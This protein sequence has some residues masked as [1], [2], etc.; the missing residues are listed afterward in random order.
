MIRRRRPVREIPFSFDSFLDVVANVVGIIIRLI[1]V[2]WVGARSY[3]SLTQLHAQRGAKRLASAPASLPADPLQDEVARRQRELAAAQ[4]R[5]VDQLRQFRLVQTEEQKTRGE[6]AGLE[7]R[8]HRQEQEKAHARQAAARNRSAGETITLSLAELREKSRRLQQDIRALERLPRVRKTLHYYTPVSAPVDA[9]EI[10]FE[11]R[12]GRVT[13]IDIAALLARAGRTLEDKGKEL[14]ERW[15]VDDVTDPVGAFRLHYTIARLPGFFGAEGGDAPPRTRAGFSYGLAEWHLEAV[16]PERGET[17]AAALAEGSEFRRVVD[18]LDPKQ[19]V[20]TIWVYPDS[21]AL[22][23]GLR[24]YL[25]EQDV[26]VAGRPLPEGIPISGSRHGT[27]S[28]GQ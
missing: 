1:L 18:S 26:V 21:F 8:R 22:Y 27:R 11:C 20:V 7:G 19:S 25:Y 9:E 16:S 3:S 10:L 15:E 4:A 12:R 28:R 24:D 5:L 14:R 2:V 17:A 6:L 13:F 23:R